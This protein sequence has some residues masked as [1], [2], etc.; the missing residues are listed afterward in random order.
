MIAMAIEVA[1]NIGKEIE[2]ATESKTYQYYC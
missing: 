1:Q 2:T